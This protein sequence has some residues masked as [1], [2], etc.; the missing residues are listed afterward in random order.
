MRLQLVSDNLSALTLCRELAKEFSETNWIFKTS[1]DPTNEAGSGLCLWDYNPGRTIPEDLRWAPGSFVL[2]S[3]R[4]LDSFRT[5]Y[6]S[7]DAGIVLRPRPATPDIFDTVERQ[8]RLCSLAPGVQIC[9][10]ER[11]KNS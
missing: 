9:L 8:G 11:N 4:D 1:L 2:L 7:A 6:P 10:L 5:A 3:A